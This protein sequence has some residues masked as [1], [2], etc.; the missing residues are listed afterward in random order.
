VRPSGI[1]GARDYDSPDTPPYICVVL[2]LPSNRAANVGVQSG[3]RLSAVVTGKPRPFP[4]RAHA[5]GAEAA[6]CRRL[7]QSELV[8]SD[9]LALDAYSARPA[10]RRVHGSAQV[11]QYRGA[12]EN[13]SGCDKTGLFR[14]YLDLGASHARCPAVSVA[15]GRSLPG[16]LGKAGGADWPDVP[17]EAGPAEVPP[18][19]IPR[20]VR[21]RSA[22]IR[23][24]A[25]APPRVKW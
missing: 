15:S 1:W 2:L 17:D 13:G 4:R 7:R 9:K 14:R 24:E 12:S 3:D 6:E 5:A 23:V 8:R 21:E 25:V 22:R 18:T 20:C 10:R 16:A 19:M 11:V